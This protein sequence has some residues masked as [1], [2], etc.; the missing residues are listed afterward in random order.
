[1]KTNIALLVLCCCLSAV[2]A[3]LSGTMTALPE[4]RPK[5]SGAVVGPGQPVRSG[6]PLDISIGTLDT[7]GGTTYDWQFSGPVWRMIVDSRVCGIHAVWMY[8]ADMSNTYFP[9]RNMRYNFYNT[10]WGWTWPDPDFMQSGVNVFALR[11][12]CGNIDVDTNG[13]AVISAHHSTGGGF[14]PMVGRDVDVGAGIFEYSYGEP[15]VDGYGWPCIGVNMNNYC[16]LA[17]I[18]YATYDDLYWS[19]LTD[20]GWGPAAYMASPLFPDH[21]I[22]TSKVPGSNKVCITWVVTPASGSGQKPGFYRES[23]DGGDNWNSPVDIGFPP[24]FSPGS[25]TVP[26]FDVTSLFP[27]YDCDDRLNIVANVCPYVDDTNWINPS[28]IWHYCPDDTPHW[29]RIHVAGCDPLNMQGSVGF[30]AA[31]ACR[32]SIGQ[33]DYGDLFVAWEQFDSANV[34]STTMR[35]R[36]DIW[37]SGSTDGGF[38]WSTAL[39]LTT[40][41]TASCRFPSICDLPW[42]GDS[43]A[44]FYEVDQCAGFFVQGE[45]PGTENPI[46]VQKVPVDSVIQRGPY[47]GRLKRPNGGEFFITGDTFTIKWVVAPQTF[48]HGVLSLSTDGGNTFPTVLRDSIPPA[49]TTYLWDSIPQLCCSLCRVKFEAKDSLGATVMSDASYR[50]FIIDTVFV[51]V[52]EGRLEPGTAA[53]SEPTVIRGVLFLPPDMTEAAAVSDRVP[54]IALLDISGRKVMDLKPGANDVSALAPGIYFLR[55]A[56]GVMRDGSCVSK[57]IV[58]R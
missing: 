43:L 6:V 56:S 29:N 1:V 46:V 50:D 39:K 28:E 35:L 14:A 52:S 37:A 47:Y 48:D 32:P 26:S 9:D 16:Q 57:V 40:P 5:P 34:E 38:T 23:P 8:S 2:S 12:G 42:P 44:V 25:D 7:I 10:G 45:G 49:D 51:G 21:N 19:R 15:T 20:Q 58:T 30:N 55:R 27:F 17:M 54:R 13:V 33:D 41:G 4:A 31:Y 24:A 3:Q 22:A 11:S 53:R 18:D 36:A